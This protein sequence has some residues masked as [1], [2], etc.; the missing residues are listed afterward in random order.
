MCKIVIQ[1]DYQEILP[2]PLLK[3][4]V[5]CFWILE[6]KNSAQGQVDRI[7]PDGCMELIFHFGDHFNR[8]FSKKSEKQPRS[9]LF[10]QLTTFIQIGPSG[11][12]GIIAA[13]FYPHGANAF[14]N[15][16]VSEITNHSVDIRS[17]FGIEG[18]ELEE[19]IITANTNPERIQILQDFLIKKLYQYRKD[20]TVIKECIREITATKGDIKIESLSQNLNISQRQLERKFASTVGLNPKYLGRIIRFNNIFKLVQKKEIN[21]LTMLSHESGYYDQ[22]HFIRDFK[23]FT[24]LNPKVYFRGEHSLS[25]LFV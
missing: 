3:D 25:K 24:G 23:Q 7:L 15:F 2:P 9:F 16:P 22:A 5:K 6:D 1:L 4:Y 8:Y 18:G 14:L 21:S 19:R 12:T 17:L 11:K 20:D 10:G 13:R